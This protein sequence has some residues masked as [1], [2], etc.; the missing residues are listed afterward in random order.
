M[1]PHVLG[2]TLDTAYREM[3]RD[4]AREAE[5]LDWSEATVT[6]VADEPK[7]AGEPTHE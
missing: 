5:A 4:E 7:R 6:D 1:R 2:K 3:A